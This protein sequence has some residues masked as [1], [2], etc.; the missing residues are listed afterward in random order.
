MMTALNQFHWVMWLIVCFVAMSLLGG[1]I[2]GS[3]FS[4]K[5]GI[6]VGAVTFVALL[7][8]WHFD[9]FSLFPPNDVMPLPVQ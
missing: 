5:A 6:V 1:L 8:L 9:L 3:V 7:L 2:T 4:K